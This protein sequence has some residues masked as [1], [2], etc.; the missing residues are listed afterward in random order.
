[1]N[2][3]FYDRMADYYHLIFEDWERAIERQG[4]VL[5]GVLRDAGVGSGDEVLDASC[6]IGTQTLGLLA[7]GFRV[8]ASDISAGA[9]AAVIA[10][11]I[12][13]TAF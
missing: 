2:E 4:E 9:L 11:A 7:R 1:M 13:C 6:G 10:L 5:A 3:E 8:T 12:R